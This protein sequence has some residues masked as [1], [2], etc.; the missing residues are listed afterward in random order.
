MRVVAEGGPG[1]PGRTAQLKRAKDKVVWVFLFEQIPQ[2]S[3]CKLVFRTRDL[4][5]EKTNDRSTTLSALPPKV[6]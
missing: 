6:S 4:R 1:S 3:T 2:V 5:M